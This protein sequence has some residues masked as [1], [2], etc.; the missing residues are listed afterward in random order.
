MYVVRSTHPKHLEM[1]FSYYDLAA[2]WMQYIE[3]QNYIAWLLVIVPPSPPL[4]GSPRTEPPGMP[5]THE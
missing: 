1:T 5:H 2:T 3:E 4:S